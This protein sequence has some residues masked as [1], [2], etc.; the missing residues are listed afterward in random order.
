MSQK[1]STHPLD[2]PAVDPFDIARVAANEIAERTGVDTTSVST[3]EPTTPSRST[4]VTS[5][6]SRAPASAAS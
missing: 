4:S 1:P 3:T 2:D 5:A 6:P